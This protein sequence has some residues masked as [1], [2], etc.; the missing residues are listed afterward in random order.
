MVEETKGHN[1]LMRWCHQGKVLCH[2][3]IDV[4]LTHGG[5]NSMTESMA[6]GILE[7]RMKIKEE[8]RRQQVKEVAWEALK[9]EEMR[10]KAM[11][12]NRRRRHD[13]P[14]QKTELRLKVYQSVLAELYFQAIDEKVRSLE[15]ENTEMKQVVRLRKLA[16]YSQPKKIELQLETTKL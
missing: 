5:W 4:F 2:R 1:L 7:F 3:T 15:A 11:D 10:K 6:R 8:V 9:G 16:E 14:R 12:Q 13:K